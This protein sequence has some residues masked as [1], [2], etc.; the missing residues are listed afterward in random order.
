RC[1][2][3]NVSVLNFWRAFGY[4]DWRREETGYSFAVKMAT[5]PA[6]EPYILTPLD[7][8][9]PRFHL[10]PS[11]IFKIDSP[12]SAI[13]ILS[14][15]IPRLMHLLPFLTG[16]VTASTQLEGKENVLEVQPPTQEFLNKY[17]FLHIKNHRQ[18]ISC[19]MPGSNVT[20]SKS[21]REN[22][23]PIPLDMAGESDSPVFRVQANI[24]SDGLILCLAFHH[25]ALDGVGLILSGTTVDHQT[26]HSCHLHGHEIEQISKLSVS[27]QD[28]AGS[29]NSQ[30]IRNVITKIVSSD[31][32]ASIPPPADIVISSIRQMKVYELDFGPVFGPLKHLSMELNPL[33]G[34]CWINPARFNSKLA[35]WEFVISSTPS[36]L[37]KIQ[38]DSLMK[39]LILKEGPRL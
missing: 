2:L 27:L 9:L 4:S 35:P 6:F 30:Y 26:N 36:F 39:W 22:F 5:F 15:A 32:W 1:R 23:I 10:F 17:P 14:L 16:N 18:S 11:F 20:L 29:I 21:V 3:Q 13:P 31:N 12:S 19:A 24:M 7:H 33:P 37:K 28:S 38:Q 8:C 25:M 34:V